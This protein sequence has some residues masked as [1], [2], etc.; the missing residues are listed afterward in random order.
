MIDYSP[1]FDT[2]KE[3]NMSI[4]DLRG[5]V[6][7]SDTIAK[8]AKGESLKLSTIAKICIHLNVPIENVVRIKLDST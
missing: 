8:F 5:N 2:L 7:S 1:L 3:K 6:V 4:S